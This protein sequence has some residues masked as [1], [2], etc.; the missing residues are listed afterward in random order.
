MAKR[1]ISAA[2]LIAAGEDAHLQI[3]DKVSHAKLIDGQ[4]FLEIDVD[5]VVN[6][7]MQP[8]I[9]IDIDELNDLARSIKLHGLIQPI[10]VIRAGE[11][12]YILK[13]GQRRLL[14]H[15]NLG[16]AKIK[17]IVEEESILPTAE[18]EK[19]LFEIA[20][21]E[22]THRDNLNPLEFALS[23]RKA[24]DKKLYNNLD[25][26]SMAI[27]K[28][29]SYVSKA[30]KIL[31]LNDEIIAD[32]TANNSTNDIEA[33]YEIQKIA[34]TKEQ[35]RVY[36]DF[37]TKKI[38]RKGIRELQSKVSHAKPEM[39]YKLKTTDKKIELN[40]DITSLGQDIKNKFKQEIEEVIKKYV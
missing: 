25:E 19:A 21:I 39:L 13:A 27:S 35:S 26:L 10:A 37:I 29:K 8:R 4:E 5:S 30:L 23:L 18:S 2:M 16:L 38:D 12:K 28:S 33:L 32:L 6:N 15:K 34:N 22:N 7:P 20:V 17:A 11:N 36:Q 14:V 1:K 3:N 31:L 9:H 40:V 24:L